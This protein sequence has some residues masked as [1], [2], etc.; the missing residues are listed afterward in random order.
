MFDFEDETYIQFKLSLDTAE[1][2]F[3]VEGLHQKSIN[4]IINSV[5]LQLVLQLVFSSMA[6]AN[7][8]IHSTV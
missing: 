2:H 6:S 3:G 5:I 8:S 4:K 7:S 1:G